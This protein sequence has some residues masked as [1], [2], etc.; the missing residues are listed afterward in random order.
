MSVRFRNILL[1]SVISAAFIGPGTVTTAAL[2]GS[3]FGYQ[4]IWALLFSTLATYLLQ[5]G[6]ARIRTATGHSIARV[7][8]AQGGPSY[9]SVI[10]IFIFTAI[11]SGCA[12]YEAGNLLGA[13]SGIALLWPLPRY[14]VVGGLAGIATAMLWSGSV[15]LISRLL[16]GLVAILGI[17]FCTV[18]WSLSPT[19]TELWS[20]FLPTFPEG[21]LYLILGL[22]GTTVVPYNLFLGSGISSSETL[23]E[24]RLSL[25]IAIGLGGVVSI[26]VLIVG[27]AISGSFSFAL[28]QQQLLDQMGPTGGVLFAVGLAAAGLTSAVTAP[29]AAAVTA[30]GLFG[31]EDP[32]GRWASNGILYRS[33]WLVALLTGSLFALLDLKPIPAI[34]LA[35]VLNGVVLPVVAIFIYRVLND[36][37]LLGDAINNRFQ[38]ALM[39]VIIGITLLLGGV[40]F[41][42]AF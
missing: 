26:A 28:L 13:S 42:N 40:N 2:A 38:N 15:T 6:V 20:G 23:G 5:E 3:T 32:D 41:W 4:L 29:F 27:S 9:R 19:V 16:G 31:G 39:G 33:V 18:A 14:W 7:L 22:I 34:V 24:M 17:A 36:R 10:G 35:Q 25:G 1:W 30:R 11:F 37:K 8:V 12:A 21:S